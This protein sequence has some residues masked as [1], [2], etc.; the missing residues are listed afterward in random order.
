M[1]RTNPTPA[2]PTHLVPLS[3]AAEHFH[4]SVKTLRRRIA[5]G[6]IAGYRVGRLIRVDLDELT[7]NLVVAIPTSRSV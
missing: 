6:T 4:V 1:P 7:Q 2:H 3:A 5:D